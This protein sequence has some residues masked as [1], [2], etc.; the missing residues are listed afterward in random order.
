MNILLYAEV[1][2][3]CLA[4]LTV[5]AIG[6]QKGERSRRRSFFESSVW[7]SILAGFCDLLWNMG[8]T[9][10]L[11][12]SQ[13]NA[14]AMNFVYFLG[15][16]GAAFFMFLYFEHPAQS[17]VLK[18]RLTMAAAALPV[19][20][21]AGLLVRS[22]FDGCIFY[23][24][25]AGGYHRGSMF[26]M[27]LILSYGYVVLAA[28]GKLLRVIRR[29]SF[30]SHDELCAVLLLAVP[31]LLSGFVQSRVP[32]APVSALGIVMADLLI[33]IHSLQQMVSTD[34]LTG[35]SNRRELL[36][37]L[38]EQTDALNR[39]NH[40][41]FLFIDIDSFKQ[42]NDIYGHN[43]GDRVLRLV[44]SVLKHICLET[45]GYCGRYGGDEFAV[46][47]RMDSEEEIAAFRKK[48]CDAVE[49]KS[50]AEALAYTVSVSIG[51]AE[52]TGEGMALHELISQA[53]SNMY[54][55]KNHKRSLSI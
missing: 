3:L 36:R 9:S 2:L 17:W 39:E 45:N 11:T 38:A 48:I 46:L 7:C 13:A 24:D 35:I 23:I 22:L 49:K 18:N 25:D 27:Q 19:A 5:I 8:Q 32:E 44:A 26:Y 15:L 16:S 40:L 10:H 29:A 28:A 51:C 30:T 1:N 52:Y 14:Y 6:M 53:D 21:M 4:I 50:K 31:A 34:V 55:R 54:H 41:Y 42:I 37:V 33:Y 12:I 20:V 47:Q 43:E